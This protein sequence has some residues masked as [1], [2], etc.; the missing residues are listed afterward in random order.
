[1]SPPVPPPGVCRISRS[2]APSSRFGT[3]TLAIPSTPARPVSRS[4]CSSPH[5]ARAPDGGGRSPASVL[6]AWPGVARTQVHWLTNITAGALL[7][8]GVSL[9]AFAIA[10]RHERTGTRSTL[11]GAIRSQR[12]PDLPMGPARSDFGRHQ[13]P[14]G[15]CRRVVTFDYSDGHLGA[16]YWG[17]VAGFAGRLRGLRGKCLASGEISRGA[18]K[19]PN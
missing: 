18:G 19:A 15:R 17:Q 14:L 12:E 2:R 7:G 4:S 9:L 11:H 10:Q 5:P 1:V 6:S 8:S 13:R 16:R 3:P